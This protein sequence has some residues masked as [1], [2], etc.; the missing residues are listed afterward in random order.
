VDLPWIV[1]LVVGGVIVAA[2]KGVG[3]LVDRVFCLEL[4]YQVAADD[5]AVVAARGSFFLRPA[6]AT[7]AGLAQGARVIDLNA[8][9]QPTELEQV[10][11]D[12]HAPRVLVTHLERQID[13]P[14][15]NEQTLALLQRLLS[16]PDLQVD[17]VSELDVLR[18]FAHRARAKNDAA[19]GPAAPSPSQMA[20]WAEVLAQLDKQRSELPAAPDP[21]QPGESETLAYECRWTAR[22]RGIEAAIRSD[23]RWTALS[24]TELIRHVAD[25]ADAHYRTLWAALTEE[26]RLQL[27]QLAQE[28]YLNPRN[29]DLARRL[30]RRGLIRRDPALRVI[31]E[32]FRHFVQRAEDGAT[33]KSWQR[34]AGTSTWAWLRTGVTAVVVVVGVFLFLTQPDVYAKWAALL[35]ALTAAGG[36]MSQLLGLFQGPRGSSA[37]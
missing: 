24:R 22:L 19:A 16:Q 8:I 13:D 15:W 18:H 12:L 3:A 26:E 1:F 32:S 9:T 29:G 34:A 20:R 10:V 30:V 2:F 35:T 37:K 36:N 23:R 5:G 25:V 21:L 28:G 17:V 27:F 7:M 6:Q 14:A 33:I 11:A 31:N 4:P